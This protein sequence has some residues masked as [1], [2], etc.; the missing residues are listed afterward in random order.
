MPLMDPNNI[1][2]NRRLVDLGKNAL[3]IG[4]LGYR[5]VSGHASTMEAGLSLQAPLGGPFREFAGAPLPPSLQIDMA[6]D[7]GGDL[8]VRIAWFYLKGSF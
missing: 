3:L 5:F 2:E 7:F 8:L 1:L 4:R 6:S